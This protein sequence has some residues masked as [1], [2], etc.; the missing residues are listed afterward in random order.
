MKQEKQKIGQFVS[1]KHAKNVFKL[2]TL[3]GFLRFVPL[4]YD[5]K[6]N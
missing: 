5:S 4:D 1:Q 2:G 6:T 3:S